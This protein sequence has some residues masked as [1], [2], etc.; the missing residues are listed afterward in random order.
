MLSSRGKQG[1]QPTW[2]QVS[3][4]DDTVQPEGPAGERSLPSIQAGEMPHRGNSGK[5]GEPPG[6][7]TRMPGGMRGRGQIAPSYSIATVD[8]GCRLF[9]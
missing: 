6:A 5:D 8:D 9:R 2:R 1:T 3:L 4:W 7:W